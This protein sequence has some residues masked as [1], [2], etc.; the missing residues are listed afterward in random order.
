M[1]WNMNNVS[2]NKLLDFE[3]KYKTTIKEISNS[4]FNI[5]LEEFESYKDIKDNYRI[6]Q[7]YLHILMDAIN[8]DLLAKF[9][10]DI[11]D[12]YDSK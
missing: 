9:A 10:F 12:H 4:I 7:C 8:E 6:K 11:K 5:V 1:G 3:R 2:E